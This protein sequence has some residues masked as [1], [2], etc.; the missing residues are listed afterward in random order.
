[1]ACRGHNDDDTLADNSC[2]MV[3]TSYD[4]HKLVVRMG[5][6]LVDPVAY[7]HN[8]SVMTMLIRVVRVD[9]VPDEYGDRQN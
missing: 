1:M 3:D 9:V 7:H 5:Q 2:D 8:Q 4:D 6:V